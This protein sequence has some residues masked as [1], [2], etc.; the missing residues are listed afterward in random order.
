M[1]K[2][3]VLTEEELSD[4]EISDEDV[5]NPEVQ[6]GY[7]ELSDE[8]ISDEDMLNPEVQPDE[9]L[10]DE[11]I[12]DEDVLNPEVQPE[13]WEGYDQESYEDEYDEYDSD[14]DEYRKE[15]QGEGHYHDPASAEI[16]A[17]SGSGIAP[18]SQSGSLSES[19]AAGAAYGYGYADED[20]A[21]AE[22][23][24]SDGQYRDDSQ[25]GD[26]ESEYWEESDEFSDDDR[27]AFEA[28]AQS[29][30]D[31]PDNLASAL[32]SYS[33]AA[34]AA[35][36]AAVCAPAPAGAGM[37]DGAAGSGEYVSYADMDSSVSEDQVTAGL[38]LL[39][40]E[41]SDEDLKRRFNEYMYYYSGNDDLDYS[42]YDNYGDMW[43][44]LSFEKN[45]QLKSET[46]ERDRERSRAVSE[47]AGEDDNYV[48]VS[49]LL[50]HQDLSIVDGDET[51]D[52]LS[53]ASALAMSIAED[54]VRM[55]EGLM[56]LARKEELREQLEDLDEYDYDYDFDDDSDDDEEPMFM[57]YDQMESFS[58]FLAEKNINPM[59]IERIA[60]ALVEN[61]FDILDQKGLSTDDIKRAMRDNGF[62][63][64]ENSAL[65][66]IRA[67]QETASGTAAAGY[68]PSPDDDTDT[69]QLQFS[70]NDQQYVCRSG[71]A[72]TGRAP[73]SVLTSEN[74]SVASHPDDSGTG[75]T[76][77]SGSDLAD[78]DQTGAELT[79]TD[80]ADTELTG[81]EL[82]DTALAD[83]E[84]TGAELTD[85]AQ[86]DTEL[87][88][89]QDA[90]L[91]LT[92]GS[93]L[94]AKPGADSDAA[95]AAAGSPASGSSASGSA[96]GR[97]PGSAPGAEQVSAGS[98]KGAAAC[99]S[100]K[101]S[102]GSKRGRSGRS[103]VKK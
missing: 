4:D 94:T 86:A 77:L 81:A 55:H 90:E 70:H 62:E 17:E 9:E 97:V 80:L 63:F 60:D 26:D 30:Q 88:E 87:T 25:Y 2:R 46:L 98:R 15:E 59:D 36:A 21:D 51:V 33:A 89:A 40:G 92:S 103:K 20:S 3:Q 19:K 64:D 22:N 85:T 8:E 32:E 23:C 28:F 54:Q 83:T 47:S 10:S 71:D 99:G 56:K 66:E 76:G 61:H 31:L 27:Q 100:E 48:P 34:A 1:Y 52:Q 5:L 96:T 6:P 29:E 42:G 67:T 101:K 102:A 49:A 24:E 16:A 72:N 12:S 35:A 7:D 50:F 53:P 43:Q 18:A 95:S 41:D 75:L 91:A 69:L 68:V 73:E 39:E 58:R 65:E 82:T 44:D 93:E 13:Y 84:Q 45:S 14:E 78:T 37:P 74:D 11:E 38:S 79:D 57:S